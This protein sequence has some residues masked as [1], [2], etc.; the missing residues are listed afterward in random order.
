MDARSRARSL[1][2]V[3]ILATVGLAVPAFA[4]ASIPAS[5]QAAPSGDAAPPSDHPT[6]KPKATPTPVP[7]AAPTPTPPPTPPP[8]PAPTPAPTPT[9]APTPKP[10]PVATPQPTPPPT[11]APVTTPAQ[12]PTSSGPAAGTT[13]PDGTD[14]AVGGTTGGG[15]AGG[16]G[17]AGIA[18]EVM[19]ANPDAGP[20]GLVLPLAAG[21]AFIFIAVVAGRR[22][23]SPVAPA[24]PQGAAFAWPA[25]PASPDAGSGA[26][27]F[28][29]SSISPEVLPDQRSDSETRPMIP[30]DEVDL[31]RW[32]R[33]SVRR[34]RFGLDL[35]HL[36]RP[37]S[38]APPPLPG[39]GDPGSSQ[40]VDLDALFSARR[41]ASP[42]P[43]QATRGPNG[44]RR[45]ERTPE[46]GR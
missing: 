31:P 45:V 33:P 9:R 11:P 43:P 12:T 7:T 10:A 28:T 6:Q 20:G 25:G 14:D 4:S 5:W 40:F 3:A 30:D 35:P 41:A 19:P 38:P 24:S 27:P 17:P 32:L 46:F 16:D 8:T 21:A 37:A 26:T 34:E 1:L 36:R 13:A 42:T 18:N 22:R 44:K 23:R 2:A 15:T 29:W 39:S